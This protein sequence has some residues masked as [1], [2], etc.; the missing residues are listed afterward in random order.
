MPD[1]LTLYHTV[2]IIGNRALSGP[3]WRRCRNMA[4]VAD[5]Y[6]LTVIT[7]NATGAD[8]AAR[9][10][11]PSAVVF[12]P[13]ITAP[14]RVALAL[15]SISLVKSLARSTAP[16][17]LA[18]PVSPCPETLQPSTNPRDCF[19]GSGSGTWGTVCYALGLSIPVL[20]WPGETK[21]PPPP[22][23]I[24]ETVKRGSLA[25]FIRLFTVHSQPAL[26]PAMPKA[27]T[28]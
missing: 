13:A 25:G 9:S 15:R 4:Q 5:A 27:L 20:M 21:T 26:I 28:F 17:M 3:D 24:H 2:A 22:W 7:G 8:H 12:S 18:Y 10:G 19:N 16:L 6:G 23:C 11:A 1:F 14:P